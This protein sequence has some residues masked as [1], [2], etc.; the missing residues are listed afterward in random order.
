MN[1]KGNKVNLKTQIL[2]C[3]THKYTMRANGINFIKLCTKLDNKN[4][5]LKF[6]FIF[7]N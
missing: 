5:C 2:L 6:Y 1:K 7:K 4:C 3:K